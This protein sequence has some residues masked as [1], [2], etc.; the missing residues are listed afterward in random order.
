M[1]VNIDGQWMGFDG[2]GDG[3]YREGDDTNELDHGVWWCFWWLLGGFSGRDYYWFENISEILH[4]CCNNQRVSVAILI[5]NCKLNSLR[6]ASATAKGGSEVV[7]GLWERLEATMM[8]VVQDDFR[9]DLAVAAAKTVPNFDEIVCWMSPRPIWWGRAA[10]G[11]GWG[12]VD[13]VS[14]V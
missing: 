5:K 10:I 9:F 2:G 3:K 8:V 7:C 14:G 13:F 6:G 11:N 4:V 1:Q 12:G